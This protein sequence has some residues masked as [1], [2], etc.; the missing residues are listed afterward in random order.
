MFS[1]MWRQNL[2]NKKKKMAASGIGNSHNCNFFFFK[3]VVASVF[4]HSSKALLPRLF[5]CER[6][7]SPIAKISRVTRGKLIKTF[8]PANS[9]NNGQ[10]V[11]G[12]IKF[13]ANRKTCF[14]IRLFVQRF[15]RFVLIFPFHAPL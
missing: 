6:A 8:P 11:P 12:Q 15:N 5:L 13:F 2:G 9:V 10:R 3:R 4:V 1:G 14:V 7:I